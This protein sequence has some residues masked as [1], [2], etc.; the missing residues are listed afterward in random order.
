[1]QKSLELK[2]KFEV[3]GHN[4]ILELARQNL[5]I[6]FLPLYLLKSNRDELNILHIDTGLPKYEYGFSV[7]KESSSPATREFIKYL[8][9]I[10]Q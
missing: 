10:K 8:K 9:T 6:G 1:M 7:N 2:P 3:S 5:G 4:M